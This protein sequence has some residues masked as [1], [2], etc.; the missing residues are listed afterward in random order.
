MRVTQWKSAARARLFI[1]TAIL[2]FSVLSPDSALAQAKAPQD[3]AVTAEQQKQLD[4]LTQLREQLQKDR[5]AVNSAIRQ[6]GQDSNEAYTAQ[7]RLLEDRREYRSLRQSLQQAG[8]SV[9]SDTRRTGMCNPNS[10]C[11]GHEP[12]GC[13]AGA[14]DS[15]SRNGGCCCMDM[16]SPKIVH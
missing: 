15:P 16:K 3:G 9:A 13:C 2:A 7:Q 8:V 14:H 1:C 12:H 11:R 6:Q 4:R 10:P 5:D